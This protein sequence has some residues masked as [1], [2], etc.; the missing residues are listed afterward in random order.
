[1]TWSNPR[2]RMQGLFSRRKCTCYTLSA[3]STTRMMWLNSPDLS[4]SS[5][6]SLLPAHDMSWHGNPPVQ[7]VAPPSPSSEILNHLCLHVHHAIYADK[8]QFYPTH[9][10]AGGVC[11]WRYYILGLGARQYTRQYARCASSEHSYPYPCSYLDGL[12]PFFSV[13]HRS[14]AKPDG[15]PDGSMPFDFLSSEQFYPYPYS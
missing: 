13:N 12:P 9:A 3:S 7:V 2:V 5:S 11:G 4:P 6:P 14:L 10:C 8:N 1:M 15:T